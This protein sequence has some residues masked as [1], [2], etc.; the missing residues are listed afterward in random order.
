MFSNRDCIKLEEPE[1]INGIQHVSHILTARRHYK[2]RPGTQRKV[3]VDRPPAANHSY[4]FIS[5]VPIFQETVSGHATISQGLTRLEETDK[6]VIPLV[7][8]NLTPQ[9]LFIKKGTPLAVFHPLSND[10]VDF[11]DDEHGEQTPV[12]Y[13]PPEVTEQINEISPA[14]QDTAQTTSDDGRPI[15]S[16][17]TDP[18]IS[19]ATKEKLKALLHKYSSIFARSLYDLRK[20]AATAVS[21][22]VGN[23]KP[24]CSRPLKASEFQRKEIRKHVDAL[25]KA[26]I[27]RK[28]VSPWRSPCFV[29]HRQGS[30]VAKPITRLVVSYVKLNSLIKKQSWPLPS[31][32][33]ILHQLSGGR[34]F[35]SLDCKNAFYSV[36]I[37]DQDSKYTCFVTPDDRTYE[38]TRLPMGLSLSPSEYSSFLHDVFYNSPA[39]LHFVDDLCLRSVDEESHLLHLEDCFAR[40][41]NAGITLNAEKCRLFQTSI[42]FIGYK[43]DKNG[44]TVLPSKIEEITKIPPP[45]SKKGVRSFIGMVNYFS[46]FITRFSSVAAPLTDLLRANQSFKWGPAQQTSF[47][48]I[49]RKLAN[50]H[51]ISYPRLELVSEE[52][53]LRLITDAS[54]S[55][56]SG[57]LAQ[58]ID[59]VD[60]ILGIFSR[61]LT[62][63]Q[64]KW[65]T[66]ER[67][68][69][70]IVVSVKHFSHIIEHL[71]IRILTDHKALISSLCRTST[72]SKLARWSNFLSQFSWGS[73]KLFD[74]IPGTAN[75][76]DYLSRS[77]V[78]PASSF[79]PE[80][81][82]STPNLLVQTD[83]SEQKPTSTKISVNSLTLEKRDD[84]TLRLVVDARKPFENAPLL[85]NQISEF[86]LNTQELANLQ[87]NDPDFR[88]IIHHLQNPTLPAPNVGKL[89]T[90]SFFLGSDNELY[91]SPSCRNDAKEFCARIAVPTILRQAVLSYSHD[92][93]CHNSTLATFKRVTS[94]FYWPNCFTDCKKYVENCIVCSL[95]RPASETQAMG[96]IAVPTIPWEAISI[97]VLHLPKSEDGYTKVLG[98]VDDLTSYICLYPL[99]EETGNQIADVLLSHH[100]PK[101]GFP[102]QIRSDNASCNKSH[103][104][105]IIYEH[106]G[107][108]HKLPVPYYSKANALIERKFRT[109]QEYLAKA[110][111]PHPNQWPKYINLCAYTMNTTINAA[112]QFSPFELNH[113]H[114]PGNPAEFLFTRDSTTTAAFSI[115]KYLESLLTKLA[116]ARKNII[117]HRQANE[118]SY[119][120]RN[121]ATFRTLTEGDPVSL[122]I[123]KFPSHVEAKLALRYQ[124]GFTVMKRISP[125]VVEIKHNLTGRIQQV[126][127]DKVKKEPTHSRLATFPLLTPTIDK[128][129]APVNLI[130]ALDLPTTPHRRRPARKKFPTLH[131]IAIISRL[132]QTPTSVFST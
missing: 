30:S 99:R 79:E 15:L 106:L 69:Y 14:P 117:S 59:G 53:P 125:H 60:R 43:F 51:T 63:T 113:A 112:S 47:E 107:I 42:K 19:K 123:E 29:V 86:P 98:I 3:F 41:Q 102:R 127:V 91:Y 72:S 49:K 108:K 44:C 56:I 25:L 17:T 23:A 50:A 21:I 35:S 115:P 57:I 129:K 4:G 122:K 31:F 22:D 68:M 92:V 95:R 11:V 114:K 84:P 27:I 62:Q 126:S 81:D 46:S 64:Q 131:S 109:A 97:D 5:G 124:P 37:K 58:T 13:L 93:F 77:S 9:Q 32:E 65:S 100:I 38:F 96:H 75:P 83:P 71:P 110:T 89:I 55:G 120:K 8:A 80:I 76:S 10:E 36:P 128:N 52:N 119:N 54:D 88:A 28:S 24:I 87:V 39:V 82:C 70:A 104:L 74:F 40:I 6:T 105:K 2:F 73:T 16:F 61:K 34:I 118:R 18:S 26:G 101:W 132:L 20:A 103:V 130:S 67:E 12:V 1:T 7:F 66:S 48:E 116:T 78:N 90:A 111:Q 33:T 85:P 94:S 121:H 45:Q